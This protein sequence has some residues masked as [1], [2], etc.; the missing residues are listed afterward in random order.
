MKKKICVLG[1]GYIGLPTSAMFA[2]NG[3]EVIGV[4][5]NEAVVN[6]LN[7]GKIIIEEPFLDA[8]V[9]E[10][11]SLGKLK[12]KTTPE[13]ADVFIIAVPTPINEDKTAMMDY[14]E[15]ATRS[16]VPFLKKNDMVIL[17]STS[18]PG[19]VEKLMMPIL[20]GAD[21]NPYEDLYVA[22]S[23]ERVIPGKILIELVENNR[24]VGGI[25]EIS[26]K[27]VK[28]L[29]ESFVKGEIFLTDP[30]TAEMCKLME[31]TFRDVNI[32]LANELALICEDLGIN[33]WDVRTFSNKHPRVD[34]HMPG[35]GVGGHC[36]AVDPWFIVEKFPQTAKIIK[37]ARE[38][39]DAMPAHVFSKSKKILGQLAG[40][41]ITILGIT[42]KPDIDDLRESPILE[43]IELFEEVKDIRLS[44]FDPFVK[45][46]KHLED[47]I[48]VACTD[49]DLII[50]G[51][52][53]K[54]FEDI[55][56]NEIKP[57]VKDG[58]I[59]DTRN[60]YDADKINAL[61]FDYHLLGKGTV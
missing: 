6:N 24:I 39:N 26:S 27:K 48:K 11:V 21:L 30:T 51:V 18:P 42:Y 28:K 58:H 25:N 37:L 33:A 35:P 13:E 44:L 9:Y 40:K 47:D 53:H 60:F 23:P 57:L 59:L 8:L 61:G 52:N 36:L 50:L 15:A 38:T 5:V 2:N 16:I 31:N 49:S 55:D 17:E 10:V 29:Y 54:A 20:E 32:A 34:I 45:E 3:H 1:L 14:V 12:A 4:D 43:L 41:K 46:F 56:F 7:A 19:T 22:H